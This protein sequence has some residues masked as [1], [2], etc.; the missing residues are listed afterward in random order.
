MTT[1]EKIKW[2]RNVADEASNPSLGQNI[3]QA[4]KEKG[5][6]QSAFAL[7]C[8]VS[9]MTVRRW[10]ADERD[11]RYNDMLNIKR[12]LGADFQKQEMRI[13]PISN[14]PCMEARCA[15]WND[16]YAACAVVLKGV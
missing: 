5:L 6:S 1:G 3:R 4:R 14:A 11:P 8:G 2:M 12:V 10:E 9:L 7:A 15:W 16:E 13:C